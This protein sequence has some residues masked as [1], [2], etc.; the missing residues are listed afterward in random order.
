[1]GETYGFLW[2][3]A[4]YSWVEHADPVYCFYRFT[5]GSDDRKSSQSEEEQRCTY[6]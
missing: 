1:M 6:K 5:V 2:V 3:A 4:L